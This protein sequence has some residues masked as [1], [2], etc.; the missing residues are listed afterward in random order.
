MSKG[1]GGVRK[2]RGR[3]GGCRGEGKEGSIGKGREG[4]GARWGVRHVGDDEETWADDRR[5]W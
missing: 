3:K 1:E 4:D 2:Q 5:E